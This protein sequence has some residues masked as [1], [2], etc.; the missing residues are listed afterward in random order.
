E[1]WTRTTALGRE[2]G[3]AFNRR[4]HMADGTVGW[5]PGK[6]NPKIV[7]PAGPT[8]PSVTLLVLE[9]KDKPLACFVNFAMHSDTTSGRQ[10]SADYPG[11]PTNAVQAAKAETLTCCCLRGCGHVRN[12]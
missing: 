6:K 8:D 10:A 11:H 7:K 12:V 1:A 3:L 2:E 4:Y 9:T 5:N